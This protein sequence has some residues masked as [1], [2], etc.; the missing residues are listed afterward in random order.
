MSTELTFGKFLED[1]IE[2]GRA[3]ADQNTDDNIWHLSLDNN[4]VTVFDGEEDD[5]LVIISIGEETDTK[6]V[7]VSDLYFE[8][9]IEL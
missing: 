6:T 7:K 5:T 9:G 3:E 8:L 1:L 4:I 2:F